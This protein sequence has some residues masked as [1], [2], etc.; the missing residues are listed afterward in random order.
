MFETVDLFTLRFW[1]PR[2]TMFRIDALFANEVYA[3]ERFGRG[4]AGFQAETQITKNVLLSLFF[5]NTGAVF[6][7]PEN[8][9]QGYGNRIGAYVQ[10]QPMD[11]LS[12]ILSLSYIDFFRDSDKQKIYDYAILR[13]RN[14]FQINKYLFLRAIV[15]YNDFRDRLTVDT[16]VSFTYIPGT[17][18]YAGYGS[19]FEK[20]EWDGFEYR[21]ST[22]FLETQRGFFFKVSYLWRF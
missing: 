17:V 19:A 3:G 13:S 18:L 5:R 9:Y 22:R 14:T 4:G 20:L 8:P 16:L 21:E 1:L 6:Y 10:Y 11:K 12:F 2:S 15:E 7:D